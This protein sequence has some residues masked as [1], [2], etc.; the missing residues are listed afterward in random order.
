M[1]INNTL[2]AGTDPVC[3]HLAIYQ[4]KVTYTRDLVHTLSL[5]AIV[6]TIQVHTNGLIRKVSFGTANC[7]DK[8]RPLSEQLS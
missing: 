2:L 8:Q 5:V 1:C 6:P 4:K 7:Q 3:A